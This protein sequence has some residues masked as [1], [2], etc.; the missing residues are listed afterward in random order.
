MRHD[1]NLADASAGYQQHS[2]GTGARW[3]VGS[4][5][6]KRPSQSRSGIRQTHDCQVHRA[7]AMRLNRQNG[8]GARVGTEAVMATKSAAIIEMAASVGKADGHGR[9]TKA[10]FAGMT[11]GNG[12][13]R[14]ADSLR[15]CLAP[16]EGSKLISARSSQQSSARNRN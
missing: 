4:H 5:G 1:F 9:H 7:S 15:G 8:P 2:P 10:A 12:R 6:N 14:T 16:E 3:R 13:P 11:R